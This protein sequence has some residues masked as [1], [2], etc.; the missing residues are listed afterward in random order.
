MTAPRRPCSARELPS[1]SALDH[2]L[3]NFVHAPVVEQFQ[4]VLL[5]LAASYWRTRRQRAVT[6]PRR[7][8][9]VSRG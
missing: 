2:P 8:S 6:A 1:C 3:A 4:S 9:V 7:G 5:D